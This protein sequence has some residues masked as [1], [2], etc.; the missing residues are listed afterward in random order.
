M[1]TIEVRKKEISTIY[2]AI[3]SITDKKE[4][5]IISTY[6]LPRLYGHFE[7][8]IESAFLEIIESIFK[9]ENTRLIE[10]KGNF[11]YFFLY[12]M[13]HD[14]GTK[15]YFNHHLNKNLNLKVSDLDKEKIKK[16]ITSL[17]VATSFS[18]LKKFL[19]YDDADLN[20]KLETINIKV[21]LIKKKYKARCNIAHGHIIDMDVLDFDDFEDT[22]QKVDE[23]LDLIKEYFDKYLEYECYR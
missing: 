18:N 7:K 6:S 22:K 17:S 13:V 19:E 10:L 8:F 5:N 15:S 3:S 12:I 16:Y 23:T 4:K 9:D 21:G 11:G 14:L 20:R 2:L 1:D